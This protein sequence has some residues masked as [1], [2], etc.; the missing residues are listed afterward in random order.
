[1]VDLIKREIYDTW[2]PGNGSDDGEVWDIAF[3]NGKIYAATNNGVYSATF[4]SGTSYF[5]KWNLVSLLPICGK[6]HF[7]DILRNVLYVN[8]SDPLSGGDQV[9]AVSDISS[10]SYSKVE[11]LQIFR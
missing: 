9:Y 6:I 7:T 8:F 1:V 2:K 4:K 3:G 5:G 11:Y 10:L